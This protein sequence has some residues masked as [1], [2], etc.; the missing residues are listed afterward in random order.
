VLDL[1]LQTLM[2]ARFDRSSEGLLLLA[3]RGS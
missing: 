2:P 3:E 1:H